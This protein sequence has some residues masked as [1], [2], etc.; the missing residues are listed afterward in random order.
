MWPRCPTPRPDQLA[1]GEKAAKQLL[2]FAPKY[3]AAGEQARRRP[4]TPSGPTARN[5]I[6]KRAQDRA[7]SNG[8]RAGATRR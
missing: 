5:D 2:D 1:L 7:G 6:E 3:F 4:A 8:G